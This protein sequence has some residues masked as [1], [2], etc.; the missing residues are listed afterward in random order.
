[1]RLE[2]PD[3]AFIAGETPE[4]HFHVT[5]LMV[6][7]PAGKL[8]DQTLVRNHLRWFGL[9]EFRLLLREAGFGKT[10]VY[11]DF[12]PTDPT[13][14]TTFLTFETRPERKRS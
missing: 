7:D 4:W 8:V 14:D 5:A 12:A 10:E 11:G 6:L 3:A 2:G 13:P 9:E 1:M